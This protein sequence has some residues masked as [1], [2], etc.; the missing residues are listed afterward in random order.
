M[1]T[2]ARGR[3]MIFWQTARTAKQARPR[4]NLPT[5]RAHGEQ[6]AIIVDGG[7]KYAYGFR[8]QQATTKG[9]SA[10]A[11]RLRGRHRR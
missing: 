2:Q 4:V 6:L 9:R 10:A 8:H 1:L 7:E 5:A 3:E 11:R